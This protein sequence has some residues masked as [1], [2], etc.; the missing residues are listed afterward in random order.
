MA[1][2]PA[3]L[4]PTLRQFVAYVSAQA[5]VDE[6]V[7]FGSYARGSADTWSDIDL[8]VVS[9]DLAD[10]AV[11]IPLLS[12]AKVV[13]NPAIS[14]M[15]FTPDEWADPDPTSFVHEIQAT[16]VRVPLGAGPA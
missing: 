2:I 16:G 15:A 7:L 6:V 5:R 14:A 9:P 8:A 13:I 11:R 10:P 1:A 12:M 4:I 3:D